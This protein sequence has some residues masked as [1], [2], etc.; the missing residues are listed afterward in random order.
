[1]GS[2]N[3]LHNPCNSNRTNFTTMDNPKPDSKVRIY[4]SGSNHNN[5]RNTG[6]HKTV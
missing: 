5:L 4:Y 6:D 2:T 3:N 1:M